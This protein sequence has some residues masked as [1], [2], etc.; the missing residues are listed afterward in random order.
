MDTNTEGRKCEVQKLNPPKEHLIKLKSGKRG[1]LFSVEELFSSER[2]RI[3]RVSKDTDTEGGAWEVKKHHAQMKREK[4]ASPLNTK[5]QLSP[6]MHLQ[7]QRKKIKQN[8]GGWSNWASPILVARKGATPKSSA[9]IVSTPASPQG[10]SSAA[11]TTSGAPPAPATYR[12][13]LIGGGKTT[14]AKKG[15]TIV[16]PLVLPQTTFS[17]TD[18]PKINTNSCRCVGTWHATTPKTHGREA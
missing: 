5:S 18:R 8:T 4:R 10:T 1:K 17:I 13:I 16:N 15:T 12:G 3:E 11:H 7:P 14:E 2:S 6:S 9:T